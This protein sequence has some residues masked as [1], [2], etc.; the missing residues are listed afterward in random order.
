MTNRNTNFR[1]VRP[2]VTVDEDVGVVS[3]EVERTGPADQPVSL[4]I[5]SEEQTA[6]A[7]GARPV[8]AEA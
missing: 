7:G 6:I 3:V 2:K 5:A 1:F 8:G 4:R